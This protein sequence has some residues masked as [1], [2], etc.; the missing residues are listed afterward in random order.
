MPLLMF[1]WIGLSKK[2]SQMLVPGGPRS[3]S[4]QGEGGGTLKKMSPP[5]PLPKSPSHSLSLFTCRCILHLRTK[6]KKVFIVQRKNYLVCLNLYLYILVNIW[7]LKS[8]RSCCHLSSR[9]Y[10]SHFFLRGWSGVWTQG[11]VLVKQALLESHLLPFTVFSM[12]V[13]I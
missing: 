11:F 1:L 9:L 6:K 2:K 4:C 3:R 12:L 13:Y 8:G 5:S 10:E 7:A